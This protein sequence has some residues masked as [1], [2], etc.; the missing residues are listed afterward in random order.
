MAPGET[1]GEACPSKRRREGVPE[2]M[3]A[4][5]YIKLYDMIKFEADT[6]EVFRA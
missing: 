2:K 6:L 1:N 4:L 3:K 5:Q